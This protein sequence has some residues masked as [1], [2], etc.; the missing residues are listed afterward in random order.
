MDFK[1]ILYEKADG[2][3]TITLNR[4]EKLNAINFEML[5]EVWSVLQ[6]VVV[7][8]EVRVVLLTGEGRYF[9]AGADLEI[10]AAL[11]P[12]SLREELTRHWNP[13]FNEFE[14]MR[15]LTI[16][17]LN[18]PAVGAGVELALCCDLRYAGE[19]A[20]FRLPQIDF[21]VLPDAGATVRLPSLVGPARAKEL[22]LTGDTLSAQKAADMGLV[23]RVFPQEALAEE[24]GRIARKMAQKPP[25]ALGMGKQLVNRAFR[26]ADTRAG[27]EAVKNAQCALIRTDDYR[28]GVR[29][30]LEKRE[31]V[32][33]GK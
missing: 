28:E 24:V 12:E 20:T 19:K 31:P 15:K 22:I 11:E 23:N 13:V 18:G 2:V 6:E 33:Q 10:L 17:A 26:S 3:G 5:E 1:T 4:P 30:F 25:L 14:N 16:V 32:F 9:A 21:G 7:D 29:A 27:L 8:Q